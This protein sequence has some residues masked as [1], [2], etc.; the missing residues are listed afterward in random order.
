[1]V[2]PDASVLVFSNSRL[3]R[4]KLAQGLESG[5]ILFYQADSPEEAQDLNEKFQPKM[6]LLDIDS[7]PG[8][9]VL[10]RA[11][12]AQN[13]QIRVVLLGRPDQVGDDN[14][15]RF[16]AQGS[17]HKPFLPDT[18]P[19]QIF[20]QISPEN[21]DEFDAT[22]LGKMRHYQRVSVSG[23][24]LRL[25]APC[26]ER[27]D[28]LEIAHSGLKATTVNETELPPGTDVK[29]EINSPHGNLSMRAKVAWCRKG[30][31]SLLF[32]NPKPK[33]FNDLMSRLIGAVV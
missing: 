29:M 33:G 31:V 24:R 4:T 15:Q 12:Q 21:S 32:A 28:I 11:L 8:H 17:M 14:L 2:Q 20:S 19:M 18:I 30:E 13:P 27:T 9:E 6:A 7:L 23:V 3:V 26:Y 16:G 10:G 25:Y 22:V 1:M 5:N